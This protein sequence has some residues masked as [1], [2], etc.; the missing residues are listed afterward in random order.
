M[1]LAAGHSAQCPVCLDDHSIL[2]A[3][4][5]LRC[6][7]W[8]ELT[9]ALRKPATPDLQ[10]RK[11]QYHDAGTPATRCCGVLARW[12]EIA[13]QLEDGKAARHRNWKHD[14]QELKPE[15]GATGFRVRV[16][17][18]GSTAIILTLSVGRWQRRRGRWPPPPRRRR[19]SASRSSWRRLQHRAVPPAPRRPPPRPPSSPR[20]ASLRRRCGRLPRTR[21]C[22]SIWTPPKQVGDA[23]APGAAAPSAQVRLQRAS[24]PHRAAQR[25]SAVWRQRSCNACLPLMVR[26]R[27]LATLSSCWCR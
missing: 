15:A 6:A 26:E 19:S 1:P 23:A 3:V 14:L 24:S 27:L 5:G 17:W 22:S 11:G 18:T 16:A 21:R 13:A 25:H 9:S 4:C 8:V 12:R 2:H 10:S 7:V 20:A